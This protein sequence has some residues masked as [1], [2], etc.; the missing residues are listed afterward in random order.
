MGLLLITLVVS[1]GTAQAQSTDPS[2]QGT[3]IDPS[4]ARVPGAVVEL[5]GRRVEKRTTTDAL[6][7]YSFEGLAPGKYRVRIAA[8]GFATVERT[9]FL[10][11][12]P[13]TFDVELAIRPGMESVTVRDETGR[14]GTEPAL[15][16][17]AVIMRERQIAALSDD[18]DELAMQLQALAG[19][20]PGPNGGQIFVDGFTGVNLPPKSAIREVRINANPF[21]P[22]YDRPGFARVEVF[23]KPGA[24]SIRGQAFAQFNDNALNSRNP[25]FA[26]STRPPYSV[27]TFGLDLGGPLKKNKVSFALSAERRRINETGLILATTLDDNLDPAAISEAASIPQARTSVTPRFDYAINSNNTL[28]VRYQELRTALNNIGVGDFNLA[29]RAYDE[30]STNRILQVTETGVISPKAITETRLQFARLS[31]FDAAKENAPA[32]NVQGAFL[33]GGAPISDSASLTNN[34]ELSSTSTYVTGAHTVKWGGRVRR[35]Q[36]TDTS[37]NNFS[38]SFTFLTLDDYRRTVAGEPGAGPWQFTMNAGNPTVKVDQADFG[39]FVNDD[40]KARPSLTLSFGL[41][42]EVQTNLGDLSNWGP[43]FG[44]AWGIDAKSNRAAKTV[45]RAGAGIFFERVPVPVTL[46]A[47]RYDGVSQRSYVIFNPTFFPTVPSPETLAASEQPQ[48]LR[49]AY[50]GLVAPRLYQASIGI[51]RQ[52]TRS[53]RITA[54]W[55]QSR[56]VHLPNARNINTPVNDVYPLGD[57]S[58]R[59]LTESAGSSRQNQLI[60]TPNVSYRR[61]SLFGFYSLSYGEDN[62]E[63]LP[64]DPYNLRAEWGPSTYGDVRH[65]L[66]AMSSIPLPGRISLMPFFAANSG[67]PYNITTGLD[68]GLTGFPAARPALIG[69]ASCREKSCFDA[70]PIPGTPTLSR[71]FGR[72]PASV[73]LGLRLAYTWAFGGSAESDMSDRGRGPS[74]GGHVGGPPAATFAPNSGRRYNVTLSASSLNSLNRTNYAPPNGNLSSPYFGQYRSLGGLIVM[75]HGGTPTAYNRKIDLQLRFTF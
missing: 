42:Y 48:Q 69:D 71:N 57:R 54:T 64:A 3:I 40:W 5:R 32:L 36:V 68:P 74:Q 72:G 60:I 75:S 52:L 31:L 59:L 41:R 53:A 45:L 35:S 7:K 30:T 13:T 22:E 63:S 26:Q 24:D 28:A 1:L 21:S 73:N 62:N 17:A 67:V 16:G 11:A 70:N 50:S 20:S 10:V 6:G 34:F 19:P 44:L 56:G 66:V 23:T 29:S 14:I 61:F 15:N 4:G 27:R 37:R 47:R 12:H 65:R 43:R 9:D 39:I 51:E 46:N 55:V 33:A 18:P 2:L 8:K 25:L 38:G 49:P 58:I